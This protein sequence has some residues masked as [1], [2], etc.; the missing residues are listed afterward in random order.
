M[1]E[2]NQNNRKGKVRERLAYMFG[3]GIVAYFFTRL[4]IAVSGIQ[5][6]DSIAGD[7]QAFASVATAV[8]VFY[9]GAET[10]KEKPES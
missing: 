6:P 1:A 10:G 3:G 7:L 8:V 5:I 9:F 2:N 4:I